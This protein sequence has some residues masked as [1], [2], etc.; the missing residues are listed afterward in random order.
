MKK[1]SDIV[2]S[3]Q[4][5]P[6]FKKLQNF[7]CISKI[8]SMFMP[9]LHRF[10]E[11]S[12]MKNST[13]FIVLNHSAGKQEF[14]NNI[15][16]IKEVLNMITPEECLGVNINDIKTF[17]THKPRKKAQQTIIKKT[18]S[19]YAERAKGEFKI[20]MFKDEKLL[21]IAKEIREIIKSKE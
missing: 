19:F 8:L 10:I 6:Q 17:V 18:N 15:K 11:F 2:K 20:D 16:M 7:T 3:I 13:L 12:Y 21:N 4:L 1:A 14:D 5:Q 9:T